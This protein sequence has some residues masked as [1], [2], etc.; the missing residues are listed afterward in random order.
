MSTKP[1]PEWVNDMRSSSQADQRGRIE[2]L[3][4]ELAMLRERVIQLE[5]GMSAAAYVGP[6]IA[7]NGVGDDLPTIMKFCAEAKCPGVES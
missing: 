4:R 7:G 2:T 3:E 1:L 6:A 5:Q